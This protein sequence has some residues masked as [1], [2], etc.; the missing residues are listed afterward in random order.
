LTNEPCM[1]ICVIFNPAA[2]GE[3]AK[4]FR[5]QLDAIGA[6]CA[7]K[8]TAAAGMGRALA[9]EAVREAYDTIVAAGGDGTVNEVL[10]GIGDA[11][12]GLMRARLAVLPLGTANVFAREI[13]MPIH[14][15]R[16]WQVIRSPHEIAIDLAE[17]EFAAQ[18]MRQRRLFVQLAGAGVDARAVELVDWRLKKWTG[19]FSY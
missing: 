18:G 11:P 4:R 12:D 8:P 15:G 2:K 14:L 1:R 10:N 16:A 9:A 3:K 5:R 17:A 6:D 13:R 7:L 19:F